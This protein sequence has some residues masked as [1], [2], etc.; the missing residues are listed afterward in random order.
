MAT[1]GRFVIKPGA[2]HEL[3]SLPKVRA[4]LERRGRAVL[5]AAGCEAKV[6]AMSSRQCA[7]HP[8]GRWRVGVFTA[9]EEARVD[10]GRHNTLIRAFSAARGE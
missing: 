1:D 3:R 7:A 8:E 10:N 9:T 2:L 4:E 5:A 6:Y